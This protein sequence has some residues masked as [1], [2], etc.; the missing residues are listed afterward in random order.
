MGWYS[1]R[2]SRRTI[3]W[4]AVPQKDRWESRRCNV[5]DITQR[6]RAEEEVAESRQRLAG[7]IDSAM[8]AIV[9]IDDQQRI[10]LFNRAAETMFRCPAAEALGRPLERF[11]PERFRQGHAGH[12]RQFGQTGQTNRRMG[13]LSAVG[14]A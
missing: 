7:I 5:R 1:F 3:W 6:K 8:D 11:I 13:E 9:T 10:V 4:G 12:V 14:A 2:S